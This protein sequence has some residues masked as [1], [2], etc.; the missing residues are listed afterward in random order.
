LFVISGNGIA[1]GKEDQWLGQFDNLEIIMQ[2]GK[3]LIPEVIV[4]T[5]WPG[6]TG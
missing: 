4:K 2:I 5:S 6:F 1:F 3:A